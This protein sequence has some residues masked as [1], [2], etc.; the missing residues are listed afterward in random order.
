MT[1]DPTMIMCNSLMMA[2]GNRMAVSLSDIVTG[3]RVVFSAMDDSL[4]D[5]ELNQR[6]NSIFAS[7]VQKTGV[8]PDG[9]VCMGKFVEQDDKIVMALDGDG[10][11]VPRVG[12]TAFKFVACYLEFDDAAQTA[13]LR[14]RL[15]DRQVV[16]HNVNQAAGDVSHDMWESM[17][18]SCRYD[19]GKEGDAVMIAG[20]TLEAYTADEIHIDG[21]DM[22]MIGPKNYVYE[23]VAGILFS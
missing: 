15:S 10:I 14:D 13:I 2:M 21:H 3:K 1:N 12:V 23:K 16:F 20:G 6:M 11:G 22:I 17:R 4:S 8:P 19:L 5:T 18:F 7:Y 9:V